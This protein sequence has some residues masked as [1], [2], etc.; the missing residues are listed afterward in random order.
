MIVMKRRVL[1]LRRSGKSRQRSAR[2]I[3]KRAFKRL[4]RT[5]E[6][7][8]AFC[9]CKLA[10]ANSETV[11]PAKPTLVLSRLLQEQKSCSRFHAHKRFG[12]KRHLFDRRCTGLCALAIL[13]TVSAGESDI[14]PGEKV[15]QL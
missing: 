4:L 9:S 13:V 14:A 7:W 8:K 12:A 10:K 3:S 5:D 1:G 6:N 2:A 15:K 11:R